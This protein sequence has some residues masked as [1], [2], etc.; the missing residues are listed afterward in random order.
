MNSV[1]THSQRTHTT[2][3]L[4]YSKVNSHCSVEKKLLLKGWLIPSWLH[5]PH[6]GHPVFCQFHL[7][8]YYEHGSTNAYLNTCFQFLRRVSRSGNG[9]VVIQ[10]LTL[11]MT[12]LIRDITSEFWSISLR[13]DLYFLNDWWGWEICP[14]LTDLCRSSLEKYLFDLPH[15]AP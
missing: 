7:G 12:F 15:L 8:C 5:G 6:F 13:S 10:T 2:H 4:F 11:E 14:V 1:L 3:R 9:S